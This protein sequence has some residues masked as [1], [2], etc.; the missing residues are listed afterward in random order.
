[1]CLFLKRKEKITFTMC[2]LPGAR[3]FIISYFTIGESYEVGD[4][5]FNLRRKKQKFREV[6]KL[7][8][9][10]WSGKW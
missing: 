4:V 3:Q 7:A 9:D 5:R 8:Q 10:Q 1:M 2:F 6:K